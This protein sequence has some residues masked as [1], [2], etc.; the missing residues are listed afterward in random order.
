VG[1]GGGS[2]GADFTFLLGRAACRASP[3]RGGAGGTTA[4]GVRRRMSRGRG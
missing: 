2:V 3:T 4:F 1:I